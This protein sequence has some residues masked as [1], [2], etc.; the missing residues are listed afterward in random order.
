MITNNQGRCGAL[1]VERPDSSTTAL[2]A[3][4][5]PER[6][7]SSLQSICI[8]PGR[9]ATAELAEFADIFAIMAGAG[10]V[11]QTKRVGRITYP[12]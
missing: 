3:A 11:G 2:I 10:R 12:T 8:T 9:V 5:L 7:E 4:Q 6:D 1:G